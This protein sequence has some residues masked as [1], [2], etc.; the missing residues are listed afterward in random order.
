MALTMIMTLSL[1]VYAAL[2]YRVRQAL[3]HS[4]QTFPD[5]KAREVNNP[6]T[7]WIFQF[8]TGIHLL[9][10]NEMQVIVLN[11]N[12]QHLFLI[13]LLG[14]EYEKLYSGN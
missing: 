7:R 9:F 8:F 6:T 1:L 2:E 11:M 4:S 14:E 5:Q 13:K 10:I 12:S 3:K